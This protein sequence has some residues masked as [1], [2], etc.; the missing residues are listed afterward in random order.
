MKQWMFGIWVALFLTSSYA[1]ESQQMRAN[2]LIKTDAFTITE[3]D[4]FMYLK[5]G[6][7]EETGL[8]DWGSRER[9][10]EGLQQ[11]Y[12]LNVLR[13]DA[14]AANALTEEQ[15]A[16][17]ARH[18]VSMS[19]VRQY[20][21]DQVKRESDETDYERLA[22]EYY[23]ANK[24]E[25]IVP[26]RRSLR[27]LLIRTDC[28]SPEEAVAIATDLTGNVETKDDFEAVV[29]EHTEDAVAAENGGLM[30]G[31]V[32][33][34]TVMEF[35]EAAFSLKTV[36]EIS[37]PVVSEF[38]AHVMQL[39][40]IIPAAQLEF[41]AVREGIIKRLQTEEQ[42]KILATLRMEARERRPNGLE[43]NMEALEDLVLST[44]SVIGELN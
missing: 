23:I 27:A 18:E 6:I 16:W 31:V 12:A 41:P 15:Q 25:F 37:E 3:R 30:P 28:R 29:R 9:L 5:P 34:D 44:D 17:I 40:A 2:V 43:L 7:D 13:I 8:L 35:E 42:N 36:G 39:L 10:R 4:L 21:S 14:E 24:S 33:G 19:L 11:L 22:E 20:L 38:G 26:E 1:D 32:R